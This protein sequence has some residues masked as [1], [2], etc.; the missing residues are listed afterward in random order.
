MPFTIYL[1][2][3]MLPVVYH[4]AQLSNHLFIKSFKVKGKSESNHP[5]VTF[6]NFLLPKLQK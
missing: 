1:K 5:Q 2:A 4:D 6:L 3:E